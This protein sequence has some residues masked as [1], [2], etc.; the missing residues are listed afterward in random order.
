MNFTWEA[1][2]L[3]A[4]PS[5]IPPKPFVQ[6]GNFNS[7]AGQAGVVGFP[8]PYRQAPNVELNSNGWNRTVVTDCTVTGF[9][10]K[11]TGSDDQWNNAS[12]A[13]VASGVR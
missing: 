9:K 4:P 8:I 1:K 11:N 10:W 2:G 13:W 5:A 6:K 7:V 3:R 12:V